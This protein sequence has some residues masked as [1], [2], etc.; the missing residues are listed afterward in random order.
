MADL[1]Q[2][3]LGGDLPPCRMYDICFFYLTEYAK[4]VLSRDPWPPVLPSGARIAS[5]EDPMPTDHEFRSDLR[6]A[7]KGR[8]SL[9]LARL[10]RLVRAETTLG[11]ELI[12]QEIMA[13]IFAQMGL[14]VETFDVDLDAIRHLPGFSPPVH[15]DYSNRPNVVGR[16]VPQHGSSGRSL[17]LNGHIDVVPPGEA[18]LWTTP[19][20]DPTERDGRVYGRGAGDMKSGLV[21]YC[22]AYEALRDLGFVPAAPVMF[23]SVIEEECT[24]NGAL[25][26]IARGYQADAAIIPE[27]FQQS[28]MTSQ[29]GVMWIALRITGKPAHVLEASVGTN[30][31]AASYTIFQGLQELEAEW[32]R[33]E[34]RHPEFH[35]NPHPV[36]FNLGRIEGGDWGS[37][38]PCSATML[39][40]V[41]FYPG[42]PLGTVKA[43]LEAKIAET[44]A[45]HPELAKVGV[46][47]SYAG[48]QAEGCIVDRDTPF[49]KLL[50]KA[51]QE[52]LGSEPS[53]LASTATTDVRFFELYGNTPATC[54]GPVGGSY[55][56]ID[57]WVSID[58]IL[59]VAE[60]L[61]LFTS[62]WCGLQRA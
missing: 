47:V 39:V 61:A 27:P 4:S 26:C 33:P 52:A 20:F 22:L 19:A 7:I 6:A 42:T 37:T 59:S 16:H 25:A 58:S 45:A 53:L 12:G 14:E 41:G 23:Q 62:E 38:V 3:R 54:Y 31:I 2:L 48:F 35:S 44:K 24:G 29:L 51:H 1:A 9:A 30:A 43:A 56:G 55:H 5:T 11:K 21:A 46:E 8:R 10:D 18:S 13:E 57:E 49:M 34:F 50:A 40:R 60:V 28:I 17:I 32:N 15:P 36:N